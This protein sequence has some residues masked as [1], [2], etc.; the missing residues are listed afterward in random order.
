MAIH[1]PPPHHTQ[2]GLIT[3]FAGGEGVYV[4]GS[5]VLNH[6]HVTAEC[7]PHLSRFIYNVRMAAALVGT[8]LCFISVKQSHFFIGTVFNPK[9]VTVWFL[10]FV[11]PIRYFSGSGPPTIFIAL[12]LTSRVQTRF[13]TAS[14]LCRTPLTPRPFTTT[15]TFVSIA[16]FQ[17]CLLCDVFVFL[18]RR[19]ILL[20]Y[21]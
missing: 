15:H 21:K 10:F 19:F 7:D 11:Y 12:P 16:L 14:T 17:F 4:T 2:H 18:S 13:I 1:P 3:P 8:S 9:T 6:Y 5:E 20:G